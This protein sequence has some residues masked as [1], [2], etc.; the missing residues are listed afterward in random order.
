MEININYLKSLRALEG[1]SQEKIAIL[2]DISLQSYNKKENGK[3]DFTARELK[4]LSEFFGVPMEK[5]FTTK[6]SEKATNVI[7]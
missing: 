7:A 3:V 6:V 1:L 4:Q 2:L 5:F